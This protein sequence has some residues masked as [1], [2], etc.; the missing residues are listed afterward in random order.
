MSKV[1]WKSALIPDNSGVATVHMDVDGKVLCVQM[2]NGVPALWFE[3][4]AAPLQT[5]DRRFYVLPTGLATVRNNTKYIGTV[6]DGSF[7]WHIYEQL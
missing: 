1:I 6:Q 3:T 5:A 2:Q 4:E 7:V